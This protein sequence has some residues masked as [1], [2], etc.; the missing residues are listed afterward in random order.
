MRERTYRKVIKWKEKIIVI[1]MLKA[2][3]L[4]QNHIGDG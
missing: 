4:I 2:V 3:A 1:I